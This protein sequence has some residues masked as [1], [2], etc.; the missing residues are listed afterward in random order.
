MINCLNCNQQ[1]EPKRKTAKYCSDRCRKLAFQ[2]DA[3]ISV[4][5]VSVPDPNKP[6]FVDEKGEPIIGKCKWCGRA[7]TEKVY[8]TK[9][10][11]VECCY[12]CVAERNNLP[13]VRPKE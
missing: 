5:A 6:E 7:I 13:V 2:K 12:T 9:W 3:K 1:F 11:L 4:P 10:R 8:G